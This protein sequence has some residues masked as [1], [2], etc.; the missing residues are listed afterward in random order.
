MIFKHIFFVIQ[1]IKWSVTRSGHVK[2][3]VNYPILSPVVSK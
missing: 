2:F 1:I 3:L